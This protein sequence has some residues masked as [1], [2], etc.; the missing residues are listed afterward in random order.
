MTPAKN[1]TAAGARL[2]KYKKKLK[3]GMLTAC[4]CKSEIT[5]RYL[6]FFLFYGKKMPKI[7]KKSKFYADG[8]TTPV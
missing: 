2:R 8:H 4:A 5:V 3:Q 6:R 1:K 7:A